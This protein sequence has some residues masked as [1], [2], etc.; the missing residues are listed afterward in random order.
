MPLIR[1]R[2]DDFTGFRDSRC[3]CGRR[4]PTIYPIEAKSDDIIVTPEGTMISPSTLT[5]P[6]K[7]LD[8]ILESQIVQKA[9]DRLVI[10]IVPADAFSSVDES[11]LV[12][13]LREYVGKSMSIELERVSEIH[14]SGSFKKRFVISE[15][16]DSTLDWVRTEG[17]SI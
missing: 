1:Y 2:L 6:F 16:N 17:K 12:S 5:F 9:P 10:R 3:E 11:K 8:H 15:L 13:S 14:Q 7:H 4:S